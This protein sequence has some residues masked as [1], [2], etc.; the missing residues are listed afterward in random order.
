MSEKQ[1]ITQEE[2]QAI[3]DSHK[4]WV[5][6]DEGKRADL[7]GADLQDADLQGAHLQGANLRGANLRGANLQDADLQY[8]NLR[9]ANLQDANLQDA[10]LRGAHLRGANLQGANFD[11]SCWPLRCGSL[12]VEIDQKRFRQLLYHVMAIAPEGYESFFTAKQITEA[13]K[14]HR[15]GEV[16][17]LTPRRKGGVMK[18]MKVLYIAGPYRADTIYEISMNIQEA[19]SVAACMSRLGAVVICPHTM[20]G[21]MDGAISSDPKLDAEHWVKGGCELVRR[22][23]GVF[24]LE[25]WQ[26]SAGTRE[27][28]AAANEAGIPIFKRVFQV[29]EWLRED[30][31][32]E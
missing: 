25:N 2:L 15:I 26:K 9:G 24:L 20:T 27:E 7:Q 1:K 13:N 19:R 30:V 8:A 29:T 17:K 10:N 23:D 16:A 4:S 22:C 14:F 21:F 6:G 12:Q 3:L 18:K 32:C 5:V 11:F 28:I 31:E